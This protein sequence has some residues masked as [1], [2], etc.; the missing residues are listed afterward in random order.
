MRILMVEGSG[1]GFLSHYA[2][3]LARGLL[4]AGHEVRLVT[5]RRDELGAWSVP[6]AKKACLSAG[7]RGWLC[8]AREV[9]AYRPQVVHL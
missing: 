2:H 6:F 1:R 3:A 5:G 4:E 9:I 8:L 7:W